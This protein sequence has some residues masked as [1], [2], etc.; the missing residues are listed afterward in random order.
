M[1]FVE[2]PGQLIKVNFHLGRRCDRHHGQTPNGNM[3]RY[4]QRQDGKLQVHLCG[5]AT[6]F[7]RGDRNPQSETEID[8]PGSVKAPQFGG[9]VFFI[10]LSECS[11]NHPPYKRP[12]LQLLNAV[13]FPSLL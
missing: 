2:G 8:S 1:V 4:A 10:L 6:R 13:F 9:I 5:F 11:N 7:T 3:E 12:F